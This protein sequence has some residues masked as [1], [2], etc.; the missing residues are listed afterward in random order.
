MYFKKTSS[1]PKHPPCLSKKKSFYSFL[2]FR[3]F[4][5][6]RGFLLSPNSRGNF[7][8]CQLCR[9]GIVGTFFLVKH[10]FLVWIGDIVVQ[11]LYNPYCTKNSECVGV[12]CV[13]DFL[14]SHRH[15]PCIFLHFVLVVLQFLLLFL[16]CVSEDIWILLILEL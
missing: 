10:K 8:L 11:N 7:K 14:K 16:A 1:I 6:F 12:Y 15:F 4:F 9:P 2:N 5:R 13:S 3:R